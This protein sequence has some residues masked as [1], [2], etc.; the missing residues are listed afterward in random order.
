[1]IFERSDTFGSARS[2]WKQTVRVSR[3][4]W[5]LRRSEGNLVHNGLFFRV[6]EA[7]EPRSRWWLYGRNGGRSTIVCSAVF[8]KRLS[9]SSLLGGSAT[10]CSLAGSNRRCP[11]RSSIAIENGAISPIHVQAVPPTWQTSASFGTIPAPDSLEQKLR[12]D[13]TDRSSIPLRHPPFHWAIPSA[14]HLGGASRT[15]SRSG[16]MKRF[17]EIL[18]KGDQG[19]HESSLR[20]RSDQVSHCANGWKPADLDDRRS[21]SRGAV[22][23]PGSGASPRDMKKH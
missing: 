23:V 18:G 16:S 5:R 2:D 19:T 11:R 7:L 17:S 22:Q 21:F 20:I 14:Y 9:R 13:G 8:S 6:V 4:R 3:L 1:M 10:V 12:A 15:R